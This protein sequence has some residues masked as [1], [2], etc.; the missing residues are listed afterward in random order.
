MSAPTPQ[1][2]QPTPGGD[3][4][5]ALPV[6]LL[7]NVEKAADAPATEKNFSLEA[8]QSRAETVTPLLSEILAPRPPEHWGLNE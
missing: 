3:G 1:P 8:L 2:N 6:S 7:P 5:V 4:T